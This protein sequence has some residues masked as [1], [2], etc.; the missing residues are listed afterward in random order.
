[1]LQP[2]RASESKNRKA[3]N[4][5]VK[6]GKPYFMGMRI[7]EIAISETIKEYGRESAAIKVFDWY[8]KRF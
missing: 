2:M 1:M 5:T 6:P 4:V 8:A 7:E 3:P